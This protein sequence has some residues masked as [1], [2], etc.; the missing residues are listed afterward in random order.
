[1][2]FQIS[3]EM[4]KNGSFFYREDEAFSGVNKIASKVMHD[5][6]LVFGCA[7]HA[8][9]ER[10]DLGKCAVIYGTVD[11]S[12]ILDELEEKKLIDLSKVRGKRE[13]YLFQVIS[14]P[15]DG[16]ESALVI[17]GSDKRGTIYG[18]FYLSEQ[19]GVSPL[20]DW[21]DVKPQQKEL[22]SFEEDLLYISKEPSV[23]YR[24]FFINDEWPAFG[25]WTNTKFGGFNAKMYEHVFEL[26]LRLKGNYMWPAMWSAQFS[27]DG[28]GLANAEL[29]DEL[30]VVMG[31]S[32]HEPCCRNG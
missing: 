4:L 11:R 15:M 18:L 20:V 16:V 10:K 5:V 9:N 7:P 28:P 12:P 14:N 17:A 30:G 3:Q 31:A 21:C 26:L 27:L 23:R 22:V 29:A 25:T 32:H 8:T 13:V 24:G 1:M 19:L 6:E 2:K